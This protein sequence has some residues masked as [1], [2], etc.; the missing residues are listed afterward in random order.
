MSVAATAVEELVRR[1][2]EA[3]DTR[4]LNLNLRGLDL[5]ELPEALCELTHLQSLNASGNRLTA[6]PEGLGQLTQLQSLDARGNRITALPEALGQLTRL[7]SLDVGNNRLTALPEALGRLTQLEELDVANNRLTNLPE[8]V[9][10]LTRLRTLTVSRNELTVLP[11][12]LW[13]LTR[14]ETLGIRANRLPMLPEAVGQLT[15]LQELDVSRND[16]TVLPEAVGELRLLERLFIKQNRLA[17]LPEAIGQLTQ[18]EWID[19]NDNQFTVLPESIGQ[20]A[21][22]RTL[23]LRYNRLAKLPES[24]GRLTRLQGFHVGG[25]HLTALPDTIGQL[26]EL[27]WLGIASNQFTALPEAIWQLTRLVWLG[28]SHNKLTVLPEAI[29]QLTRLKCLEV[30][31]NQLTV[32]PES[33][34]QLTRLQSL[35]VSSNWLR[36]L[37]ESLT[38][39]GE[40][41]A[42]DASSNLLVDLPPGL[43]RLPLQELWLQGNLGLGLSQALLGP[44]VQPDKRVAQKSTH[45]PRTVLDAFHATRARGARS[46][47]EVKLVLVGRGAAGKTSIARRIVRGTFARSPKE[48]LGIE[49]THWKLACGDRKVRVN[50]WDFAGQVVTHSTHAFFLSE[51]TVYIVVLTG[52]EDTQ[53]TDAEYWLR[54]LRAFGTDENGRVSPVIVALNKFA[55]APF[56]IDRRA[57][58]EKYPFIV[59]FMETDCRSGLGIDALR[60]LLATTVADMPIV[61]QRFHRPWLQIKATI[62]RAQRRTPYMEY[63][64]F[65]AICAQHGERE[66]GGQRYLANVFHTL[67]IAL[68]YGRDARLRDSTVLDPRWV[69]DGIYRLLREAVRDD[70]SGMLTME[71]VGETLPHEPETMRR[72]LVDLMCRFDLAIPVGEA[73]DQWLVPQRLPLEQPDLTAHWT[74]EDGAT[75]V[76]YRY[77][78][79]PEGLLPRFIAR[80]YP[81]NETGDGKPSLPRWRGGVILADGEARALARLDAEERRIDVTVT[82]PREARLELLGVIR[83]DFGT[84]HGDIRGL[85]EEEEL[86]VEGRPGIF[87]PVSTLQADETNHN[88]SSASTARGTVAVNPTSELNRLSDPLQREGWRWRPRV[89]ISYTSSDRRHK[90]ELLVRLKPLKATRGL[91]ELW[92]DGLI[93]PGADWD[94]EI[95][96]E[97]ETA[98]VMLLLVSPEFI[99]SDYVRGVEVRRAVERERNGSCVVIP[100]ILEECEWTREPFGHLN[101]IPR[102]G[103][104]VRDMKPV[105]SGWTEVGKEIETRLNQLIRDRD[106]KERT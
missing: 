84:I 51:S 90:D 91:L 59:G 16:L 43:E 31:E 6:L 93:P 14:L 19:A 8:A 80:T 61:T 65:Q 60:S 97:L 26:T 37:P 99:A 52:R 5:K 34:G 13:K 42:L 39:C 15:R 30:S 3:R 73:N 79:V 35:D 47:N 38:R 83:A 4:A 29:G 56:V 50:I 103:K 57:L 85:E 25:N 27:E 41:T 70:G 2:A 22:L 106:V 46:L 23:G 54:L 63:T 66:D 68:N 100:I 10:A 7:R 17:T 88:S 76:R 94:R 92:D 78:T 20:L 58:Q 105:R 62:E 75:R 44:Y 102:K 49:I 45:D 32:L 86:E 40:L 21:R 9:G 95:R 81:L 12:G 11:E 74:P 77:T 98:D 87:V 69:T 48:T 1:V 67:G 89:F 18:L 104:P 96:A 82:G 71:A 36:A 53:K 101:A 28:A 64:T 72:Y 55:T 33:I 24:I